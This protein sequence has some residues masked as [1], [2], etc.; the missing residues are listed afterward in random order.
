MARDR[1]L[2]DLDHW[3]ISQPPADLEEIDPEG[4]AA[5]AEAARLLQ[6][7]QDSEAG[8]VISIDG[9][10][11]LALTSFYTVDAFHWGVSD[12]FQSSR[13]IFLG[14]IVA[15]HPGQTLATTI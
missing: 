13:S 8:D 7:T 4:A 12:R 1:Y 3:H 15:I 11:D 14:L 2:F 9:E 5:A 6:E 10:E